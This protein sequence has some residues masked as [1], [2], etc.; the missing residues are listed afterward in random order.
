LGGARVGGSEE[1][2]PAV[3]RGRADRRLGVGIWMEFLFSCLGGFGLLAWHLLFA[4]VVGTILQ[5]PSLI[6]HFF[7]LIFLSK[8]A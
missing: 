8:N 3:G 1:A 7:L 6:K 5:L 2:L 4:E